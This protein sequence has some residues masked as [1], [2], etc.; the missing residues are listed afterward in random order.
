MRNSTAILLGALPGLLVGLG[1]L[2][3]A[4]SEPAPVSA[5]PSVVVA[6]PGNNGPA[7]HTRRV[8]PDKLAP[9]PGETVPALLTDVVE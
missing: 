2:A 7:T 8:L 6:P 9:V 1:V 5:S 4:H 3:Y